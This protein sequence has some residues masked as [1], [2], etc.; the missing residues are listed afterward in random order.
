M[1]NCRRCEPL[2]SDNVDVIEELLHIV[3][4]RDVGDGMRELMSTS[5]TIAI[6]S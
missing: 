3:C 1:T 6:F 4:D 2:R 5:R